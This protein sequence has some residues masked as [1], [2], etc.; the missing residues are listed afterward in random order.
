MA[1][2]DLLDEYTCVVVPKRSQSGARGEMARHKSSLN[3][4]PCEGELE[5]RCSLGSRT[6][7]PPHHGSSSLVPQVSIS[8]A[9]TPPLCGARWPS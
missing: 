7:N 3:N 6:W 8:L 9:A 5:A 1:R 4:R 2:F